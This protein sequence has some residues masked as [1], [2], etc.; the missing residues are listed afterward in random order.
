MIDNRSLVEQVEA[1]I[2][3]CI[4]EFEY[5]SGL[6]IER[7][8]IKR[9]RPIGFGSKEQMEINIVVEPN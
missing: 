6:K 9:Y 4:T 7:V 8:D 5:V 2:F 3:D 1:Y